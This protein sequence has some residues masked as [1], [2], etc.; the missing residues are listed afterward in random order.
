MSSLLKNWLLL[1]LGD[2]AIYF[3]YQRHR[4]SVVSAAAQLDS[5]FEILE[6]NE[7]A[8][9][10][11]S[12]FFLKSQIQYFG[13]EATAFACIQNQQVVGLCFYWFGDLYKSRNFWPLAPN[14]AKLVQI[15]T[16]EDMQG[17]GIA[18][19]LIS[20]SSLTMMSRGFQ[21][22]YARVWH[23]NKPS[24]RAFSRSGWERISLAVEINPFRSTRP[25]RFFVGRQ[26]PGSNDKRP[27]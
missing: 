20:R 11:S 13:Q 7:A 22:L 9:A 3:I 10:A 19:H 6:L 17:R 24:W 14:H 27:I 5:T 16:R 1:L 18:G 15:V 4:N 26:P 8:A 12:D 23:S 25:L 21:S 2:Y